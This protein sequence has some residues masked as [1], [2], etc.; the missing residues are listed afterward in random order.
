MPK[1]SSKRCSLFNKNNFANWIIGGF[2]ALIIT[3]LSESF[4]SYLYSVFLDISGKSIAFISDLTYMEISKGYSERM[5]T[6]AFCI[7]VVILIYA[8]FLFFSYI[9]KIHLKA[10]KINKEYINSDNQS[11]ESDENTTTKSKEQLKKEIIKMRKKEKCLYI[12][13]CILYTF[14]FI[15]LFI[16]YCSTIYIHQKTIS[17][18]NNIEIVS[19][20][21]SDVE[22]KQ[23]KSKFHSM[24]TQ[25]DYNALMK[26][27]ESIADE[28]SLKL[29]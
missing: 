3:K 27:L 16:F 21:I 11:S 14:I 12:E 25:Y 23:L 19:P 6:S 22:Y 2:F 7:I 24:E 20:Y 26:E 17:L 1:K 18:T 4:F 29:K 10:C 9:T 8:L 13:F 28:Y 5:A 15:F